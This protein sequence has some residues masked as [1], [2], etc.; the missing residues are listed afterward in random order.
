[1][2]GE[3][4][5]VPFVFEAVCMIRFFLTTL[6]GVSLVCLVLSTLIHC[7][8]LLTP[9]CPDSSVILFSHCLSV[10]LLI[11]A[12][13]VITHAVRNGTGVYRYGDLGRKW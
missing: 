13:I 8:A 9:L 5:C 11:C 2:A 4:R 1:M 12:G 10:S 6:A 3:I 7:M